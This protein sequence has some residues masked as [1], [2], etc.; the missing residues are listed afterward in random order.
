MPKK[1]S[2]SKLEKIASQPEVNNQVAVN[3]NRQAEIIAECD[4][5][6]LTLAHL[7]KTVFEATVANKVTIDKDGYE[8]I[9]PDTQARLKATSL[10]FDL[11][12]ETNSKVNVGTQNNI[13][14][15]VNNISME[16]K[17]RLDEYNSSNVK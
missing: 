10:G 12:G 17:R 2:V 16:A 6:G 1:S 5:A 8:H 15:V 7:V 11:R 3:P 14:A 4:K 9:E 13:V